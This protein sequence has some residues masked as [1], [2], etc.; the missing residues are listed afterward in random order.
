MQN[1][2]TC[3]HSFYDKIGE[4]Y[5]CRLY[6]GYIDILLDQEECKSY[7]KS[8]ESDECYVIHAAEDSM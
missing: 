1:C 6:M 7:E 2:V 4:Q 3:K 5:F 8:E